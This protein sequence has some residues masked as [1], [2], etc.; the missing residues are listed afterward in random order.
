LGGIC[1][2]SAVKDLLLMFEKLELATIILDEADLGFSFPTP[3]MMTKHWTPGPMPEYSG[4]KTA[5]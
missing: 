5:A 4:R 2:K 1:G 3:G